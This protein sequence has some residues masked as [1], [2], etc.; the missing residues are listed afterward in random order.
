MS[1][2]RVSLFTLLLDEVILRFLRFSIQRL[3]PTY[4]LSILVDVHVR[5]HTHAPAERKVPDYGI[6]S[7]HRRYFHVYRIFTVIYVGNI[8]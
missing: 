3:C 8:I 1:L 6:I 2:Q 7:T 5:V 4:V